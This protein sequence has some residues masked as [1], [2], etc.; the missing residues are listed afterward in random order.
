MIPGLEIPPQYGY[1]FLTACVVAVIGGIVQ[2]IL[3]NRPAP[4]TVTEAW[5]ETRLVRAELNDF[6]GAVDV[7]FHWMERAISDWNSGKPVPRLTQRERDVL[8]KI[9]PVPEEV[10]G[11]GPLPES[12]IVKSRAERPRTR[13]E[14]P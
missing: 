9:R 6:R 5:E 13:K 7:F 10:I 12:L 14:K 8:D 4:P 11:T 2:R 3:K 1:P